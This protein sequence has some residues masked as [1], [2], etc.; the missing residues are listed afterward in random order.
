MVSLA[1]FVPLFLYYFTHLHLGP[2]L[3]ALPASDTVVL[4]LVLANAAGVVMLVAG[5][6]SQGPAPFAG[7]PLEDPA[8]VHRIT[9]HPVF[10]GTSLMAVA[11]CIANGYATDV[12]FFGGIAVFSLVSCRCQELRRL[13]SGDPVYRRFHAATAFLP[14]TGSGAG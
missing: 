2:R 12:A 7:K 6:L 8:G 10:M 3:W 4:L 13:A 11:Q 5:L 1:F 9:R 14:F